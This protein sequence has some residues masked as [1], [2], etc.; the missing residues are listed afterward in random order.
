MK[1]KVETILGFL[2]GILAPIFGLSLFFEM[3]PEYALVD[4]FEASRF[5]DLV[6]QIALVV[7]LMDSALFFIILQFNKESVA[8]GVLAGMIAFFVAILI[9]RFIL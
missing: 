1:R 8:R 9:Y 2:L 3:N 6:L 4:N 5:K 7:M